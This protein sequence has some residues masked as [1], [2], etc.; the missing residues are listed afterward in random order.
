[1]LIGLDEAGV[2][3]AFG[4]LWAAAVHLAQPIAGLA[5][6]KRLTERRRATLREEILAS[7]VYG[8]GEVTHAE[9]DRWGL[10]EA[11]RLVFERALDDMMR[12]TPTCAPSHLIVDGTIFRPWRGV[13]HECIEKADATHACV[14]AASI[15]AKTTRDAQVLSMCDADP[16]LDARYGIRGNKGYLS[17]R[18]IEGLRAHGWS[19][20]HRTSYRIR[21][22][23]G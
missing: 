16:S 17:A 11:R 2:G 1:M 18:H 22:L 20:H 8:M 15:L 6:S 14:S 4:S 7:A 9:I 5:D 23:E 13:P 19:E 10:G 12:R 21:A 3:P